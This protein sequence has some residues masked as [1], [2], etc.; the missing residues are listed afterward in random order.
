MRNPGDYEIGKNENRPDF[1][2]M[3]RNFAKYAFL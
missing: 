2:Q 3:D 1:G